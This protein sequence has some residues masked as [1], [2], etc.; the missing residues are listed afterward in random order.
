MDALILTYDMKYESVGIPKIY[1]GTEIKKYQ[2]RISKYYWSMLSTKY[3]KNA[4]K[5][6]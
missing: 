5:T 3:T 6:V 4:I 2:I 1:L